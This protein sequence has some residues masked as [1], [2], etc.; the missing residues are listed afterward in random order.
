MMESRKMV[1]ETKTGNQSV[2]SVDPTRS[3]AHTTER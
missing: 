1:G 2:P 3:T